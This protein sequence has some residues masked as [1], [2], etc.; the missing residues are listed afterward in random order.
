[1]GA[2]TCCCS[3]SLNGSLSSTDAV[4]E[5]S[6]FLGVFL[7]AISSLYSKCASSG[8]FVFYM[9]TGFLILETFNLCIDGC[10][11]LKKHQIKVHRKRY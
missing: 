2:V 11:F 6:F 1:M 8:V 7:G 10:V 4:S 5:V 9:S 3:A